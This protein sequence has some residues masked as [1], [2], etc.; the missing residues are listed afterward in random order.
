[1]NLVG[2]DYRKL[3]KKAIEETIRQMS[4]VSR[5]ILQNNSFTRRGEASGGKH[6]R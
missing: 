2:G 5:D 4:V 3:E 6:G 1:M